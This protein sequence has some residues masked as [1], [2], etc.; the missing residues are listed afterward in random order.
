MTAIPRLPWPAALTT[1]PGWS[2]DLSRRRLAGLAATTWST[3][4]A[5]SASVLDVPQF[6]FKLAAGEHLHI[7]VGIAADLEERLHELGSAPDTR[8][9][10]PR[11]RR[12]VTSTLAADAATLRVGLIYGYWLPRL[13]G[14]FE[15]LRGEVD[16][17]LDGPTADLVRRADEQLRH[18]RRWGDAAVAAACSDGSWADAARALDETVA[19]D[20]EPWPVRPRD[21]ARDER[22]HSF[23]HTRDYRRSAD[24]VEGDSPYESDLIEL[25]R[26]NR[27][28]IDAIETFALSIFDLI[29]KGPIEAL[30][31]LARLAWDEAR[32]A[33]TGDLVLRERGLDPYAFSCSLIGI[34]VRAGMDGYDP[35]AQITL[36]GELGIIGPMRALARAAHAAGDQRTADVFDFICTDETL[37]L[38]QSRELLDRLHPAGG[39]ERV[40]E[41]V[42][43]RAAERIAELGIMKEEEFLALSRE[44]IFAL[45]GE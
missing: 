44:E 30:T 36:F 22:F 9:L 10:S 33:A 45:I 32:H 19:D 17:L 37:H 43:A 31:H 42:R 11:H 40:A 26:V 7:L 18:V 16:T 3:V 14:E 27:D 2:R 5:L 13:A 38:R 8:Q 15:G 1:T 34:K 29:R 21:G 20:S 28:E 23:S 41:T 39:L 6:E 35:W 25:L 12:Q 24:W 4:S